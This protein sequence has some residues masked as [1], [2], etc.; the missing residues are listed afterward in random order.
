MHYGER[1]PFLDM[2][3]EYRGGP[4]GSGGWM[5]NVGGL[6]VGD[7]RGG[8]IRIAHN[9]QR[10][11]IARP[12]GRRDERDHYIRGLQLW[13]IEP[14]KV[15]S[16]ARQGDPPQ[17]RLH[18]LPHTAFLDGMNEVDSLVVAGSLAYLSAEGRKE[19]AWGSGTRMVPRDTKGEPI[20]GRLQIV[21][22]PDGESVAK[23]EI[24]SAV[25]NNGLAVAGGRL[26]AV[27]EDGT[28]RCYK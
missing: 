18:N 17:L 22:L 9:G 23:I 6:I 10:A 13:W 24:D 21:S 28:V 1:F 26:Y 15:P 3:F 7:R 20:P 25:I 11:V 19:I 4:H 2:E 5:T 16:S 14:E 8:R 12:G 27:C